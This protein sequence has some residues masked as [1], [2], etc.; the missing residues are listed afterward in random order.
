MFLTFIGFIVIDIFF[1]RNS[2]TNKLFTFFVVFLQDLGLSSSITGAI[3]AFFVAAA[4]IPLGFLIY[5]FYFFIRWNSPFSAKGIAPPFVMGRWEDL[6]K[7]REGISDKQLAEK[8][9][10]TEKDFEICENENHHGLIWRS[11]ENVLMRSYA[12]ES[13]T[14][15]HNRDKYLTDVLHILGSAMFGMYIAFVCYLM[16][17][18]KV[19]HFSTSLLFVIS[20]ILLAGLIAFLEA[21][22]KKTHDKNKQTNIFM[23]LW[24][25]IIPKNYYLNYMF[26]IGSFL[27]FGSPSVSTVTIEESTLVYRIMTLALVAVIYASTFRNHSLL[28]CFW[29]AGWLIFIGTLAYFASFW[30]GKFIPDG[31]WVFGW[32]TFAFYIGN[33]IFI[34]NRQNTRDDLIFIHNQQLR[35][36]FEQVE[37]KDDLHYEIFN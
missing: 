6:D 10:L 18:A 9:H 37:E 20:F 35:N 32:A 31:G 26:L 23:V 33:I 34:K 28:C 11:V 36:Y 5:Q 1:T 8:V 21:E 30:F 13:E 24:N 16:V 27:Y 2:S 4:G 19:F 14:I 3:I 12:K 17:K 7:T 15:I 25:K 22:D 29:E